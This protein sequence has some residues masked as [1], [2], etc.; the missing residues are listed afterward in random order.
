M[1]TRIDPAS[2]GERASEPYAAPETPGSPPE[3]RLALGLALGAG[4][5]LGRPLGGEGRAGRE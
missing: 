2:H 1:P 5:I 4:L 3:S